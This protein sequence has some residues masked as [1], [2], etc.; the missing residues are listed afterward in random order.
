MDETKLLT[1]LDL[2]YGE[3]SPQRAWIYARLPRGERNERASLAGQVRGPFS[4]YAQTLPVSVPLSD[5]GP[6]PTL[7]ARALLPDP[8]YWLPETALWYEVT[9]TLCREGRPVARVQRNLALRPFGVAHG[10]LKLAGRTWILRGI[11]RRSCQS[12]SPQAWRPVSALLVIED[13]P[14]TA[15]EEL[16]N[17]LTEAGKCGV[18][19][20]VCLH[21]AAV[22]HERLR[23]LARFPAVCLA[24]LPRTETDTPL[25]EA[26]PNLLLAQR[27]TSPRD[28]L[29][30]WAQL[31]WVEAPDLAAT[32]AALPDKHPRVAVRRLRQALAPEAARRAC[33]ALQREL[34]PLGLL[35]GYVV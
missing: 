25:A 4:L 3:L 26:A 34:A 11:G 18:P 10:K 15:P 13:D 7:L 19:A 9:V 32:L 33:D 5:A 29:L 31:A 30:P 17:W 24:V 22:P 14:A 1:E 21:E 2:F 35:A 12:T 6:G 28:R 20:A 23:W 27:V 16:A 8:C